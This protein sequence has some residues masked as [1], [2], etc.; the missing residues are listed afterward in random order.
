MNWNVNNDFENIK[1]EFLKYV[2]ILPNDKGMNIEENES[3]K[4]ISKEKYSKIGISKLGVNL[5]SSDTDI[6]NYTVLPQE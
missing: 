1:N 4:I 3:I 6:N 5:F 2:N